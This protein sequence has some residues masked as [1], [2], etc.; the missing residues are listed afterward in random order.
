MWEIQVN[1]VKF[2]DGRRRTMFE[3]QVNPIKWAIITQF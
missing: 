1:A 3:I 2:Q